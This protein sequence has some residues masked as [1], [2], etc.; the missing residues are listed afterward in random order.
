MRYVLL[1]SNYCQPWITTEDDSYINDY[2]SMYTLIGTYDTIE[3][4][5]IALKDQIKLE[6]L[7]QLSEADYF[8]GDESDNFLQ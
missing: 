7:S 2:P 6:E 1:T 5:K 3:G 4:A 8:N